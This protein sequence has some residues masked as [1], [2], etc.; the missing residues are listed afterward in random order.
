[1]VNENQKGRHLSIPNFS[2]LI[3]ERGY[4]FLISKYQCYTLSINQHEVSYH[5]YLWAIANLWIICIT[6]NN[7]MRTHK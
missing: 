2:E 6:F 5:I 7:T 4:S 1:M 3:P